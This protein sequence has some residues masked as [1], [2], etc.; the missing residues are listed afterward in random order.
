MNDFLG[1][2]DVVYKEPYTQISENESMNL[3]FR[4][5]VSSEM[6]ALAD[7]WDAEEE[8]ND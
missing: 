3:G 2:F 1:A 6:Q 5:N 8:Q 4:F 7:K